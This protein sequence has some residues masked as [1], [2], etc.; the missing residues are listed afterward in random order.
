MADFRNV[1]VGPA[2]FRAVRLR[3]RTTMLRW[4]VGS[5]DPPRHIFVP[6]DAGPSIDWASEG[7]AGVVAAFNGGFKVAARAGGSIVDGV[8]LAPLVKGMAS[9]ALNA[10][11]QWEMGVWGSAGFPSPGFDPIAV[12]QNLAP[13]VQA[14]RPTALALA[15]NQR[16]WGDPLGG[17]L[18]EARSGLGVDVNGNLIYV[19]TMHRV[20]GSDVARAL[21][22]AGADFGMELDMN[23]F[24][25]M[26]GVA[27]SPLHRPTPYTWGLPQSENNPTV[28]NEGWQR[29]FFV[30]M[31]RPDQWNCDWRSP[32]LRVGVR[33]AQPQVIQ[34]VCDVVTT[35]VP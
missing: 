35:T 31:S 13:L 21:V 25:P 11:G 20:L 5:I 2:V 26:V 3:A 4:H 16:V 12:R 23:P 30:A 18:P 8:I 29:D 15:V 22:A 32:G 33:A 6:R 10:R 34:R 28:F 24:W 9:I 1:S 7:L 19:A 27:S 17:I 14:G